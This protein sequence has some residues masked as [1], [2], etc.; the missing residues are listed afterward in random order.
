MRR[1]GLMMT[2]SGSMP[3]RSRSMLFQLA[4]GA[5]LASHQSS[6]VSSVSPDDGERF[7]FEQSDAAQMQHHFR[8]SARQE[9]L[10]SGVTAGAIRQRIDQ[11]GACRFTRAQSRGGGALQAGVKG[12]GGQVQQQVGGAA[13]SRMQRSSHCARR[14][15]SGCRAV[16]SPRAFNFTIARAERCA[17]SSQIGVS[18]RRKSGMRE[19]QPQRFADH[20]RCCGGPQKLASAARTM[21]TRGS[22]LR[23]RVFQRDKAVSKTRANRLDLPRV[24][25]LLRA[26]A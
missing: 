16:V 8:N 13:K 21:R 25:A 9:N 3:S 10:H 5:R 14:R 18:R 11:R 23:C 12:D 6:T 26:A 22:R 7:C 2:S 19:R 15:R 4:G 1:S 24:F 20:L 17:I